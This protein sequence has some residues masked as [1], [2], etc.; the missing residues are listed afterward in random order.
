[1]M[2]RGAAD[3]EPQLYA[4][5]FE[6]AILF[7]NT[8]E[9]FYA[10]FYMAFGNNNSKGYYDLYLNLHV[11]NGLDRGSSEISLFKLYC[12]AKA[13]ELDRKLTDLE[14][15]SI[16]KEGVVLPSYYFLDKIK[17][18]HNQNFSDH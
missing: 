12:L 3:N 6:K 15:S 7:G 14:L 9:A 13:F 1:M 4:R 8:A 5:G 10:S 11:F 17:S 18:K 16:S 2:F